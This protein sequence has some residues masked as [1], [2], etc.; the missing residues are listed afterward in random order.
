MTKEKRLNL[1]N[2]LMKAFSALDRAGLDVIA[3]VTEYG[4]WS[5]FSV[6]VAVATLDVKVE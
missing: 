3:S 5:S 4:T 2:K 1:N 6:F